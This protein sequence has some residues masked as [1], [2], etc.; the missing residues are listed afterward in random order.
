MDTQ[1]LAVSTATLADMLDC[2]KVYAKKI[3]D[4]ANARIQVG[5]KILWNVEKIQ[6][7][8]NTPDLKIIK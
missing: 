5:G 2:G 7:F 6:N 3:G 4:A 1:K 8:L